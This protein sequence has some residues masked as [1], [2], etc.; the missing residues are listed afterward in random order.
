MNTTK[1]CKNCKHKV[2]LSVKFCD[3]CGN[4]TFVEENKNYTQSE[5]KKIN[6]KKIFFNIGL[7][8]T[9]FSIGIIFTYSFL[10]KKSIVQD[11]VKV[12]NFNI[13]NLDTLDTL[14]TL[15]TLEEEIKID[16]ENLERKQI[17]VKKA[18]ASSTFPDWEYITYGAENTLDGDISTAWVENAEGIG[19]GEWIEYQFED[20]E[21]IQE[22]QIYNGYGSAYDRNGIANLI[23][24]TLS[25]GEIFT[26]PVV[27]HWNTLVLP[28]PVK[29]SSVRITILNAYSSKDQDTCISEIL[30]Y[31]KFEDIDSSIQV[32]EPIVYDYNII[33]NTVEPYMI[34]DGIEVYRHSD[35]VVGDI[36]NGFKV[37][38]A[39]KN[40][41]VTYI[42]YTIEYKLEPLDDFIF[43]AD[44]VSYIDGPS[45]GY[46]LENVQP[47]NYN[48]NEFYIDYYG[49][50]DNYNSTINREFLGYNNINY[51][52][53]FMFSGTRSNISFD[54]IDIILTDDDLSKLLNNYSGNNYSYYQ[55][56]SKP[57]I[58][59]VISKS[60]FRIDPHF[61]E[62]LE[63]ELMSTGNKVNQQSYTN[64]SQNQ[65]SYTVNYWGIPVEYK[66]TNIS[67][68]HIEIIQDGLF[69]PNGNPIPIGSKFL[70]ADGTA[71]YWHSTCSSYY[72]NPYSVIGSFSSIYNFENINPNMISINS[73]EF[74]DNSKEYMFHE[75]LWNMD[76]PTMINGE[77]SCKFVLSK[78]D[79]I[80]NSAIEN[81]DVEQGYWN[82]FYYITSDPTR[83]IK[84]FEFGD[85]I[86]SFYGGGGSTFAFLNGEFII[87]PEQ[88]FNSYYN[89]S[90]IIEVL[91]S[92][93]K[94]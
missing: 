23:Q 77:P 24:V 71:D 66:Y 16:F 2:D 26:Y 30:I 48:Y 39:S 93:L 14:N 46:F 90:N 79:I 21:L 86:S 80:T 25:E 31:N 18:V 82:S 5:D 70:M 34:I 81:F 67:Y 36:I 68:P 89:S 20:N 85:K 33:E 65:Q 13:D 41:D 17:N 37:V 58:F 88:P 94:L 57:I 28:T 6:I 42:S 54:D 15:N 53:G 11:N 69:D 60:G 63:F 27:G 8:I 45:G 61:S 50:Y 19:I 78:Y 1:N 74:S 9:F 87:I 4:N 51:N 59:K 10:N 91:K 44:G 43:S 29:T 3:K 47:I 84:G 56:I 62:D 64:L 22:I 35:L 92:K 76:I 40:G 7:A 55:Y 83:E 52:T 12:S 73:I 75:E 38:E 72:D 49:G 32:V